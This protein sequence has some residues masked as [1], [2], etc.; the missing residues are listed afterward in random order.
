MGLYQL[1]YLICPASTSLTSPTTSCQGT[2]RAVASSTT[3]PSPSSLIILV[4][5]AHGR[6]IHAMQ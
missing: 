6:T 5:V 4:F 2:C 1:S 3:S